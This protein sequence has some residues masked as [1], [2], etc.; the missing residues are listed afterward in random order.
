VTISPRDRQI[1]IGAIHEPRQLCRIVPDAE[2]RCGDG[3]DPVAV[4]PRDEIGEPE[5]RIVELRLAGNL[6][7]GHLAREFEQRQGVGDGAAGLARIL[8]RDD[9]VVER[10]LGDG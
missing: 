9:R 2:V 6:D 1:G 10:E 7:Y 4:E 3:G 8:P 5:R